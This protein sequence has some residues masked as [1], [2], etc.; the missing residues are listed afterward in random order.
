MGNK[1]TIDSKTGLLSGVAPFIAFSGEYVITVCVTEYR[2][3]VLF[4]ESRKELHIRVRDCV[5]IKARLDPKPVTCDGFSVSFSNS[6]T[7]PSGTTYLWN[8][9]DPGSGSTACSGKLKKLPPHT[10]AVSFTEKFGLLF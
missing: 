9:G 7:L 4:A 1:V 8:F 3:G 2:N 6:E 10:T 5:P